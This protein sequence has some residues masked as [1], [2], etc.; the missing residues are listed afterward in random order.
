M[1][2]TLAHMMKDL[3][4]SLCSK[5]YGDATTYDA[6]PISYESDK[7]CGDCFLY[8]VMPARLEYIRKKKAEEAEHLRKKQHERPILK[9]G[10][11]ILMPKGSENK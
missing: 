1:N 8:Q 6:F 9:L 10:N 11:S 5:P 2:D 7:C 3:T 4:C